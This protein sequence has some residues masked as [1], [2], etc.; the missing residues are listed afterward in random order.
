M[1]AVGVDVVYNAY[2]IGF[3]NPQQTLRELTK[4]SIWI[5]YDV[6]R[7]LNPFRDNPD[8]L[9]PGTGRKRSAMALLR[10]T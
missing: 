7:L 1:P 3:P 9:N 5:L 6:D 2:D 8:P 4:Y 10:R